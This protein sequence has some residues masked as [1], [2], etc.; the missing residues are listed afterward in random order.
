MKAMKKAM[1]IV[2]AV[3]LCLACFAG[4]KKSE[5][6]DGQTL[7]IG[8]SG[9]LTGD[10]ASYGISV[11]QGAELAIEE[12][13]AAGGVNGIKFELKFEDDVAD[14]ATAV[15][16]YAT[17]YDDGM[18][19]SMGTVTSG[20]CVAVTEEVKK[21][22]MLML[23]PSASQKECTQYDNCFRLCFMDPDQGTYAAQFIADHNVGSKIAVL[24]DKSSDYS[25]G[26][27]E[28]FKAKAQE[29]NL[30]IVTEQAFTDQS[31]TDFSVQLQAIKSSGADLLFMPFYYQEAALVITQAADAGLDVTFFGVDGMDGIIAQMGEAKAELT[32][33]II[34]LTPFVAAS[35]DEK[36]SSF[37]EAYEKAYD[38]TPDQFAAD[39]YDVIYTIKAAMEKAAIEDV[40]DKELNEKLI[41]AMTEIEVDGVTGKM[42][43]SADGEPTKSAQAVVIQDGVYVEY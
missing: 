7:I 33:G 38:A 28:N 17:L 32:E 27:Y 2:L 1:S 39:A 9:P 11:Q 19:V 30:E 16:A 31:K 21:D 35:T 4:C 43:W 12:I 20:A 26:I 40:E 3:V 8:G 34:L 6:S 13:N 24:Y 15:Q 42:T 37:V 10:A 14:P 22:G 23:T 5:G 41:A 29:L 18:K 36:I 25:S